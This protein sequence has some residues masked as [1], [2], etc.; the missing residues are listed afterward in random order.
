[1]KKFRHHLS[2]YLIAALLCMLVMACESGANESHKKP[3][4]RAVLTAEQHAQADRYFQAAM[5]DANRYD[6][7]P[8][9]QYLDS[10]LLVDSTH[11]LAFFQKG[12]IYRRLGDLE[13]SS[14][15]YRQAI[16]YNRELFDA[17]Y[18]LANNAF[19]QNQFEDAVQI[20]DDLLALKEAPSFWHNKGRAHLA[21][22]ED[23]A[24]RESFTRSVELDSSYAY[25]YAS[26][27][28]L[29]EMGGNY[30]E[31]YGHYALAVQNE[32]HSD[33][34]WYKLGHGQCAQ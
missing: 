28:A 27:G 20:F 32:P 10:T 7:N 24:A 22:G 3:V 1:M 9:L 17:W 4:S 2:L 11:Y 34:Y 25:G 8:A 30:K 31:M 14:E 26:L 18:N 19:W 29:A 15:A 12:L 33:E 6:I 13:A 5:E 16:K 23:A 21:L